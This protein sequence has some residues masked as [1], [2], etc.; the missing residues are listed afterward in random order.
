MDN[1]NITMKE[2]IIL[3]E[4]KALSRGKTFNW[5]TT[6]YGKREYC[7]DEDD[8]FTNFEA[9]FPA[10]ILG[11]TNA[12]SSQTTQGTT[13]GEY[14]AE[15]EDSKIEFPAIV[16]G[17]TSTPSYEPTISLPC[18]NEI[19]FRILFDKSDDEDYTVI[20]DK[21]LFSYKIIYV[22]NLKT[23]SENDNDKVNM[24]LFLALEPD[25]SYSDNL[26]FF[27]DFETEFPAIIY[28]DSVTSK[29]DFLTEPTQDID[30]FNLKDETSLSEC[31]EKEQNVLYFNDLFPFKII[32]PDDP[33]SDKNNDDDKV[34]IEHSLGDLSI[35][36]LPNVIKNDA[37]W[38]N[39]LFETSHYTS[40]L[41]KAY[42]R[43]WDTAYCNSAQLTLLKRNSTQR[44]YSEN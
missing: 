4:E 5:Q 23:D 13:M 17:D 33:K 28:N 15:K 18:E 16:L 30:E 40:K 35:E 29:S 27:K 37:Q 2:Y 11:N 26:D 8:S 43:V 6:T 3:Q 19:D 14:E 12:I 25:V 41:H 39:K 31:D 36:P 38:S 7:N 24:P 42:P 10:I 20:F 22:N 32:Y 34:D 9:E 21:K 1:P 44:E